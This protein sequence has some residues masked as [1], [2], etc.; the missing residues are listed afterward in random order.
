[1]DD[2]RFRS[3]RCA[4]GRRIVPSIYEHNVYGGA[5]ITGADRHDFSAGLPADGTDSDF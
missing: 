4:S 3:G 1:M 5:V 2:R